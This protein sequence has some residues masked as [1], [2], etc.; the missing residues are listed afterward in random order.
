MKNAFQ[1]SLLALAVL[2][3]VSCG[4][5]GSSS[6]T[7]EGS[8]TGSTG[9]GSTQTP[10]TSLAKFSLGLSDAP[11]DEAEAV[12]IELDTV[13]LVRTNEDGTTEETSIEEFTDESGELVESI[14]V[15]LLEYQGASQ[16]KVI[17][18]A[19][20]IELENG[21]YD[22][23]F[24]VIDAGSY[25]LLNNDATEHP[26]KIPSSRLRLGEFTASDSVAQAGDEP[27]YTVEFDLRQ[28]LVQRGSGNNNNGYIIKPHGV[29]I[30]SQTSS[31]VI[32]GSVSADLT[33]LGQCTI[34]L[35]GSEVTMYGDM[36][37]Q[38]DENFV[39]PEGGIT[40]PAPIVTANVDESGAYSIA[41]VEA[42]SYQ[43]AIFCGTEEDDNVQFDGLTIPSAA[44]I[45][46]DVQS[47]EVVSQE[48]TT[49]N[50]G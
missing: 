29:R 11:V 5:S 40:A 31:G 50:F 22:L 7:S 16:I 2:S 18:E 26:I 17:D 34:Y 4:G 3:V 33:N 35:Y 13:T 46:P 21:A 36:F 6:S 48:T 14:Q 8:N 38:S 30:V 27:A 47:I 43:I 20:E 15:N 12:F 49:A 44:D 1:K 28:S 42:G 45:T 25:V 24:V 19:Q 23:E 39:M 10:T 32:E 9:D 37:D 41:F